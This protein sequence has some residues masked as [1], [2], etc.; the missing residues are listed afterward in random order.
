MTHIS[1]SVPMGMDVGIESFVICKI[2]LFLIF[3]FMVSNIPFFTM[4]TQSTYLS[5]VGK[6]KDRYL[7]F[8]DDCI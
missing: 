5:G 2:Q 3:P 6:R 8:I 4:G 1:A 7:M